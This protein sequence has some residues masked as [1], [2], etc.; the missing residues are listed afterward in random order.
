MTAR[1]RENWA[2]L[3]AEVNDA[4][5]NFVPTPIPW[6]LSPGEA[7]V[8]DAIRWNYEDAHAAWLARGNAGAPGD[9]P[10]P[11]DPRFTWHADTKAA[12]MP[13]SRPSRFLRRPGKPDVFEAGESLQFLFDAVR[14][15]SAPPLGDE[16]ASK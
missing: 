2:C 3:V 13:Y 16:H 5:Y 10:P 11:P 14:A 9:G 7:F 15:H 6:E 12:L 4:L 1:M 8:R